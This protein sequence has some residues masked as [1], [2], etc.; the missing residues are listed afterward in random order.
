M[1][2]FASFQVIEDGYAIDKNNVYFDGEIV[3]DA[4][5]KTFS[6]VKYYYGKDKNDYFYKNTPLHISDMQ[7]VKQCGSWL[8]DRNY[9]YWQD[10]KT[11]VGDYD[12]F[13]VIEKSYYA[14]DKYQ[15][16]YKDTIITDADPVSF[17]AQK[18][19]IGQDKNGVYLHARKTD[20]KDYSTLK[21]NKEKTFF[22]DQNGVYNA[23]LK[24]MPQGTDFATLKKIEQH[25]PWSTDTNN[26]YWQTAIVKGA[27]P[28]TFK[29]LP[30]LRL[31][32]GEVQRYNLYH[33]G[34]SKEYGKDDK[35]IYYHNEILKD[36]DYATFQIFYDSEEST[37]DTNFLIVCDK[38]KYYQGTATKL[39]NK[40]L[41]RQSKR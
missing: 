22:T 19:Y 25:I 5:P 8:V 15:V 33:W 31:S 9:I 18:W 28:N 38:N 39:L 37:N 32:K 3:P 30:I 12:S 24:T 6:Y 21:G 40:Y 41:E 36:A 2:D 10:G 4:D 20:V 29:P 34:N 26:V 7:S 17:Q 1:A 27:N 23:Q 11:Q 13:E 14:K 35:H 16:Y